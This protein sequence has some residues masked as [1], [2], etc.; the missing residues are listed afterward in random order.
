MMSADYPRGISPREASARRLV[1]ARLRSY[2]EGS[3]AETTWPAERP[4]GTA[5]I[6]TDTPREAADTRAHPRLTPR[7]APDRRLR[8]AIG[9]RERA[10]AVLQLA[11]MVPLTDD[12]IERRENDW[13]ASVEVVEDAIVALVTFR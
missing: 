5:S 8:E 2:C 7:T 12:E 9:A 6:A 1:V 11:R 3:E 4:G 13:L 10:Y